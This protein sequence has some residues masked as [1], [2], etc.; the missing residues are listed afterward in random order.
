MLELGLIADKNIFPV[1][2]LPEKA[3]SGAFLNIDHMFYFHKE[4]DFSPYIKCGTGI[5]SF[6]V[7][8]KGSDDEY[9]F[10]SSDTTADI[11]A[12]VGADVKFW[13]IPLN[14]DLTM[15]MLAHT[16]FWQTKVP[17]VL[18]IGY[19][20]DFSFWPVENGCSKPQSATAYANTVIYPAI[21]F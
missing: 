15:P 18:T 9:S 6:T 1:S 5:Y 21:N 4:S 10:F 19:R 12:G 8:E 16:I 17:Y 2:S 20:R 3:W 13:G 14:V 7:F 11:D